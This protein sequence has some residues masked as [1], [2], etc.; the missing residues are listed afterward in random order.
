MLNEDERSTTRTQV[1]EMCSIVVLL[2]RSGRSNVVAFGLKLWQM[3]KFGSDN[4]TFWLNTFFLLVQCNR[5]QRSLEMQK[6]KTHA[7]KEI[8]WL[9][10]WWTTFFNIRLM[11]NMKMQSLIEY[12][13][14]HVRSM[15]KSSVFFFF[16]K[17]VIA[18]RFEERECEGATIT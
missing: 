1:A 8:A 13:V 3:M 18:C 4:Y 11:S 14:G 17:N 10:H 2:I 6:K 9:N 12:K 7:N 15:E 16:F 5:A